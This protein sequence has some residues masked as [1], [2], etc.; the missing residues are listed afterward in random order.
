VDNK[1]PELWSPAREAVFVYKHEKLELG[2]VVIIK[3]KEVPN[4]KL[5]VRLSFDE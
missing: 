4:G 5:E 2:K 1:L 3:V